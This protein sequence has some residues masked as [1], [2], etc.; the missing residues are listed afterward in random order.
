[1]RTLRDPRRARH[2]AGILNWHG[3]HL[4]Y[5]WFYPRLTM[6][7][8]LYNAEDS[9]SDMGGDASMGLAPYLVS[10]FSVDV[11]PGT[12]HRSC[13]ADVHADELIALIQRDRAAAT[14]AAR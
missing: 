1:M 14:T 10:G 8:H 3:Q 11:L 2:R 4:A 13:L 7:V 12:D 9:V 5:D 6:P